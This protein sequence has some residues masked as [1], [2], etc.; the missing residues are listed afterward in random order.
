MSWDFL[1]G[2]LIGGCVGLLVAGL[3]MAGRDDREYIELRNFEK[4]DC[5]RTNNEVEE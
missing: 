2:L 4:N 3:I 5:E 1:W